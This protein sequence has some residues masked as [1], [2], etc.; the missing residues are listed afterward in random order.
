MPKKIAAPLCLVPLGKTSESLLVQ[1]GL[2]GTPWFS[3]RSR[4]SRVSGWHEVSEIALETLRDM[5][6]A[7]SSYQDWCEPVD[8]SSLFLKIYSQLK[9]S[10]LKRLPGLT[11]AMPEWSKMF[12]LMGVT[13]SFFQH[14]DFCINNLLF[15]NSRA[16][17]VDFEHFGRLSTPLHDE[18]M[19]CGSLLSVHPNLDEKIEHALW[20]RLAE[21]SMHRDLCLSKF[22]RPL[23]LLHL[24]WWLLESQDQPQRQARIDIY[25]NAINE[26][27]KEAPDAE[28]QPRLTLLAV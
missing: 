12:S 11:D 26:L 17:V 21:R 10:D 20:T 25:F 14:G 15:E 9:P 7:T 18:L 24:L 28:W 1:R 16:A 13:T 22:V 5:H 3:I 6:K 8:P 2:P 19:L 27:L 4:T 23:F